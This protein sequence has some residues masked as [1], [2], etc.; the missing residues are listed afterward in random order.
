MNNID[1][2][3]FSINDIV[4]NK[5]GIDTVVQIA[6]YKTLSNILEKEGLYK[7][8]NIHNLPISPHL[9]S[10]ANQ[11]KYDLKKRYKKDNFKPIIEYVKIA[12]GKGLSNYM[13]IVRNIPILFDYASEQKKAKD[14]FCMIIFSGLHQPTKTI[15]NKAIKFISKML[16]RKAFKVHS[17]DVAT[18]FIKKETI[19]YKAKEPFRKRLKKYNN[20]SYIIKG[21]SL[22]CNKVNDKN[23]S[24][25]LL[26]DKF[27]KQSIHQK[28]SINKNL[29]NWKRLEVE[30]RPSKKSNFIDFINSDDFKKDSLGVYTDISKLLKVSGFDTS[31]LSYQLNSLIDNRV[32]N[33]TQSKIQFNSKESLERFNK[34]DF[35]PYIIN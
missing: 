18:D 5:Q 16:K 31:Y 21:S 30:I 10:I 11:L 33:N 25:I 7:N 4:F 20:N 23:I 29:S 2:A 8:S 27:K 1:I 24:K 17:I 12:K 32:M 26:Y 3:K 15:S 22:Y 19:N 28:Q 35:K 13:I 6:N 9:K 34:S 14:T